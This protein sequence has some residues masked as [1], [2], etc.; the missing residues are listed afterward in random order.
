[1]SKDIFY[2][3]ATQLADMIRNRDLSP[4]EVMQAHICNGSQSK[5]L[6][7]A[8]SAIFGSH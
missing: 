1:M 7:L 5:S 4:V 6:R 2:S 8:I 3:D